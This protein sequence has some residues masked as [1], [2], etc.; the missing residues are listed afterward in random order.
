MSILKINYFEIIL[1][2]SMLNCRI[3]ATELQQT[4]EPDTPIPNGN[5]TA[6]G[7]G[8][9]GAIPL[10][11]SESV[12]TISKLADEDSKN[13]TP[14]KGETPPTGRRAQ[15]GQLLRRMTKMSKVK[16]LRGE[17]RDWIRSRLKG[18]ASK[19]S[20]DDTSSSD[21][22]ADN[23]GVK[24]KD[25]RTKEVFDETDNIK[26]DDSISTPKPVRNGKSKYVSDLFT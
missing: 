5:G 14:L 9:S 16:G 1:K 15:A 8:D 17:R 19:G 20:G 13:A 25:K 21:E 11:E 26:S 2:C 4:T 24:E 12:M 18:G 6:I 10:H 22:D 23:K 3:A 7:G